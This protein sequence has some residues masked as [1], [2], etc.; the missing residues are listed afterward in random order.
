MLKTLLEKDTVLQQLLEETILSKAQ[1]DTLLCE[2][3]G[4]MKSEKLKERALKR[5]RKNITLGS[6]LRTKKQA[7]RRVERVLKTIFL[8]MYLGII[9]QDALSSLHRAAELLN[10]IKSAEITEAEK[11]NIIELIEKTIKRLIVIS[12]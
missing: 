12:Q 1:T 2:L 4:L 9:P 7:C 8:L 11:R 10:Q 6:Y 5:D 3:D